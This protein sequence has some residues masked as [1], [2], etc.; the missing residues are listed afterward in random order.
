MATTLTRLPEERLAEL[1]NGY[2]SAGAASRRRALLFAVA[3]GLLALLSGW[4]AEVQVAVNSDVRLPANA[5]ARIRQT[6]LLGEKFVSLPDVLRRDT[7]GARS[8][9]QEAPQPHRAGRQS[10]R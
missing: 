10:Y 6:S 7:I 2:R 9:V 3:I 4:V 8:L 5:Y 1:L